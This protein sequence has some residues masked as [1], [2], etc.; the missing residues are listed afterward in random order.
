MSEKYFLQDICHNLWEILSEWGRRSG[1][2]Q[3]NEGKI[4]RKV[5]HVDCRNDFS[6]IRYLLS[7]YTFSYFT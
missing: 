2:R 1:L 5:G 6:D 3:L 7:P 4:Y